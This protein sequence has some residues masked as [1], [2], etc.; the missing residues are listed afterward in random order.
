MILLEGLHHISLGSSDL[1]RAIAFYQDVLDF[2]LAERSDKFALLHLDPFY[3]RLNLISG[4]RA[5]VK[6]PGETSLAFILDVDDFTNAIAELEEKSIEIIKG[7]I[8]IDG[9]ESLLISDPDG[10]LIELFYNE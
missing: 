4:Y 1:D 10:H 5:A 7:P 6:N 9:G 8:A 2:D 3:V